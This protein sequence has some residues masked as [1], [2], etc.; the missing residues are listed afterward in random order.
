MENGARQTSVDRQSTKNIKHKME[1]IE[2][3]SAMMGTRPSE[4]ISL[5]A[6]ISLIV[7]VVSV[8]IGV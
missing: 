8:P 7:L 4:K 3:I 5:I 2:S 6:S 1:M